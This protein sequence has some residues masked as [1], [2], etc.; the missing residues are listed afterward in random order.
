MLSLHPY[1]ARALLL[2]GGFVALVVATAP[3]ESTTLKVGTTGSLAAGGDEKGALDTLHNFIKSETGFENDLVDRAG[4]KDLAQ[5]MEKGEDQV[6]V[7]QGFELAWALEKYPKL[8]PL[9]VAVNGAPYRQIYL[10]TRKDNK[11]A[12]IN[13][14][15]GKKVALT[16]MGQGYALLLLQS[17]AKTEP[18][19]FFGELKFSDNVED[20]LDDVVDGVVDAAAV[21]RTSLDAFKRRKPGRFA[22]LK[23]FAKSKSIPATAI[24]YY[25]GKLDETTIARFRDGLVNANKKEKGRTLLTYFKLTGFVPPPRDFDT[26]LAEMR[27]DYPEGK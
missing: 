26:A 22:Q 24:V 16:R 14:L 20:A 13:D 8:K 15:K 18:K 1:R 5:R 17:L 7:F 25:E 2:A 10:V 6:G 3:A 27:K 23:E 21:D 4:W 11:A 12:D 9:A 19:T